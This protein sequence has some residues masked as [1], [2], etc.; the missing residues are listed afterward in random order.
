MYANVNEHLE[1]IKKIY[2]SIED[3]KK[4]TV[5]VG[6]NFIILDADG[7]GNDY[8]VGFLS[9]TNDG[10]GIDLE[11]GLFLNRRIQTQGDLEQ[12][13]ADQIKE[14][15]Y[16]KAMAEDTIDTLK[17]NSKYK[18]GDIVEVLGY[19][20]KGDGAN[21]KRIIASIDNGSG[22]PLIGGLF[23]NVV[24]NGE[25]D[26]SWFGAIGDNSTDDTNFIQKAVNFSKNI[27]FGKGIF[28]LKGTINL[29]DNTKI[30]GLSRTDTIIF[31]T[32][33][34]NSSIV[35]ASFNTIENIQLREACTSRNDWSVKLTGIGNT[36][37]NIHF[38]KHNPIYPSKT[39]K[40]GIKMGDSQSLPFLQTVKD[41]KI[42]G[43]LIMSCGDSVVI[44]N[45]IWADSNDYAI[46]I[47]GV[48]IFVTENQIV[49]GEDYGIHIKHSLGYNNEFIKI[50]NNY[51]D[52]SYNEIY[53]GFCIYSE[54]VLENSIIEGNDFWNANEGGIRSENLV[55]CRIKN[56]CFKNCDSKDEGFNDLEIKNGYGNTIGNNTFYRTQTAPKTGKSRVNLGKALVYSTAM[57]SN[58]KTTISDNVL[59]FNSQYIQSII[60]DYSN[61][62]NNSG[63]ISPKDMYKEYTDSL[64]KKMD[65]STTATP[66]NFNSFMVTQ[67]LYISSATSSTN[68]P[69]VTT[70][71]GLLEV[72]YITNN[73]CIQKYS[74]ISTAKISTRMLNNGSWTN[75]ATN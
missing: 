8:Y 61:V 36:I 34:E 68:S 60:S 29:N 10:T 42:Q 3:V 32:E 57:T 40:F 28:I 70:N 50:T 38:S 26:V 7:T 72:F 64:S 41:S 63:S 66:V 25:V 62:Y 27:L 45:E 31:M 59:S 74:E 39:G 12:I 5:P 9:Y 44:N 54:T 48:N 19:Y 15:Y 47:E 20:S 22:V 52:G 24:H 23:A 16:S 49:P 46:L 11:N 69:P 30:T 53:T 65:A 18:I 75:W 6:E 1:A 55:M 58:E 4:S 17:N 43:K 56:N 67:N 2:S 37:S 33:N 14:F 13:I 71:L 35:G 51:F 73:Y 21:H